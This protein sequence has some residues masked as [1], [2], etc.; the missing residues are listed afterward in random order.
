VDSYRTW[1]SVVF[2]SNVRQTKQEKHFHL[3]QN[4]PWLESASEL[5]RPSDRLLLAKLVLTFEDREV[6]R[7]QRIRSPKAVISDL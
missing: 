5:Y 7:N 3:V 4:T 6:S 2:P 1:A